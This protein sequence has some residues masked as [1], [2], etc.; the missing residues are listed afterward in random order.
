M[1][2]GEDFGTKCKWSIFLLIKKTVIV[3]EKNCAVTP[4]WPLF[5]FANHII[6][7]M[8]FVS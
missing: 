4:L 3:E 7:I 8:C 1:K 2:L 6:L 5:E